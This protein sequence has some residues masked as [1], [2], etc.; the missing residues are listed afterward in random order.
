MEA[1]CDRNVRM[2]VHNVSK[3]FGGQGTLEEIGFC[4]RAGEFVAVL[5]P[6]G[7]GKTTLF[8][9]ITGLLAP[10]RGTVTV[11]GEDVAH[12]ANHRRR[13]QVAVVFQQFNLVGRLSALDNVLAGRLGYVPA[14]RGCLRL[15][16]RA[17]RLLALECLERVGL[18]EMADQRADHLSGGQQQRVAIARALAQKPSVVVADEPVASLDPRTAA[19]IL[20]LLRRIARTEQVSVICSLHQVQFAQRYA[21][22]IIGLSRGRIVIDRPAGQFGR[23]AYAQLYGAEIEPDTIL[24]GVT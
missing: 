5:G 13:R 8:R 23:S 9:C 16:S 11:C 6:S 17:D 12:A 2:A 4:V 14:W 18:L 20:D 15:F 24:E 19:E 10:D 7:A 3:E 21:D 22:R 1:D